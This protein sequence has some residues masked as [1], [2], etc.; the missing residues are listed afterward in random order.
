MTQMKKQNLSMTW[1][2]IIICSAMSFCLGNV[3]SAISITP[4]LNSYM[5]ISTFSEIAVLSFSFLAFLAGVFLWNSSEGI[6]SGA[7][8]CEFC[9]S[10]FLTQAMAFIFVL[11]QSDFI[12]PEVVV[13]GFMLCTTAC[14]L[15]IGILVAYFF[16]LYYRVIILS[17]LC[18]GLISGMFSTA[19]VLCTVDGPGIKGIVLQYMFFEIILVIC[20]I[21]LMNNRGCHDND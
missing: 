10:I 21:F 5:D 7:S 13:P 3:C 11:R 19:W 1:I 20:S 17:L 12:V 14:S 6:R 2:S 4:V 15:C 9:V 16:S 18:T 8:V